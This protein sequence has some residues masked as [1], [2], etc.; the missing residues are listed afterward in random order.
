MYSSAA[1]AILQRIGVGKVRHLEVKT[2]WA[3]D[4]IQRHQAV[5]QAVS[6]KE[7]LAD[8]G[9]KIHPRARLEELKNMGIGRLTDFVGKEFFGTQAVSRVKGEAFNLKAPI[10]A[11][12]F[13]L[14]VQ[15]ASAGKV[16]RRG[17][18]TEVAKMQRSNEESETF[19][20]K[21]YMMIMFIIV[22]VIV[23]TK[24]V[25]KATRWWDRKFGG[26]EEGQEKMQDEIEVKD[27]EVQGQC[28][29]QNNRHK[30]LPDNAWGAW[31]VAIRRKRKFD[32]LE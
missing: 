21:T 4:V 14:L 20:I 24:S 32:K 30:P 28:S 9:T 11:A 10:V 5:V 16:S 23:Y 15:Q 6:G 1:R 18:S 27:V 19:S 8:V 22:G 2:L 29:Y 17:Y 25:V 3:Q 13:S 26:E 31:A 12:M 7:N